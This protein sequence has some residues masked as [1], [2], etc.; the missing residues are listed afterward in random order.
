VVAYPRAG[1]RVLTN[2]GLVHPRGTARDNAGVTAVHYQLNGG[3]WTPA[4]G[5][6]NWTATAQMQVGTNILQV[7]GEDAAGRRSLTNRTVFHY[8]VTSPMTLEI[9]GR[10]T[11]SGAANGQFLEVGRLYAL[12][13]R[14]GAGF[15]LTNW[16]TCAEE[17][18]TNRATLSFRMT[19]NACLRAVFEDVQRPTLTIAY[20]LTGARVLTNNG[21]VHPRGTARDNFAVTAVHY[22]LNNGP[23][24]PAT[25]TSN[26]TATA[27]M[28]IGTNVLSA[29][30]EDA[31]GRRSLTNRVTFQHVP[32][33]PLSLEILGSGTVSG[34]T[35]GQ[36]LEIGRN[37]LLTAR[38]VAGFV[39]T[40]WTDC[41]DVLLTNRTTL[42][43][44]MSSNACLR[45]HFI[46]LGTASREILA[47]E[48]AS[49]VPETPLV[50]DIMEQP[51][52][53]EAG[54]LYLRLIGP[55]AANVVIEASPDLLNWTPVLTN[56]IPAEGMSV[57][58]PLL[59][60]GQFF[61]A[62]RVEP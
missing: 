15:V 40:N 41:A 39:F 52:V 35:N 60:P 46:A 24:T 45:V 18:L 43:F 13:A 6:S 62:R 33:S 8:V 23:W 36:F 25:G 47:D 34:A 22:Q 28:N 31:A 10:G 51:P 59:E 16:S 42:N 7:F 37:Y 19:S 11:V 53:A 20:P 32:T 56:N 48:Q 29:C 1:T 2:S 61:R 55:A 27:T 17:V 38:A 14:P 58:V 50:F 12:T 3:P 49:A 21:L 4:T 26:W 54:Q 44:R 9:I 30:A 5:T 57:R